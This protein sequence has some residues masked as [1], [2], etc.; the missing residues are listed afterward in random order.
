[1]LE[2]MRNQAGNWMIKIVL[3]IIAV[4]FALSFGLSPNFGSNPGIA[5]KVNGQP[6]MEEQVA[7][8]YSQ[9]AEQARQRYGDN[10][11]KLEP[12]LNL[13]EQARYD[14]MD[15]LLIMQACQDMGLSVSPA[16]VQKAIAATPFFQV[17]GKFSYDRYA[18]LLQANR[19][20]ESD[21]E[22]SIANDIIQKKLSA[23]VG[24]SAQVTP[25][26]V[27]QAL[28]MALSRIDAVYVKVS[29]AEFSGKIKITDDELQAYYEQNKGRYMNPAT[30][31][32]DYVAVPVAKFRD[33]TDI[34]EADIVDAYEMDWRKYSKPA[35]AEASH[36]LIRIPE[37]DTGQAKAK[38][39]ELMAKAKA[40]EDFATLARENSQGPTA[41]TG[42]DLGAFTKGQMV[43]PFDDMVFSMKPG[44][45]GMVQT[46]FGWHVVKL[47]DIKPARTIPLD[48]VRDEIANSLREK[49]AQRLAMEAAENIFDQLAGGAKLAA[50][51]NSYAL[52]INSTPALSVGQQIDELP[53]LEDVFKA[54]QG[55]EQGNALRPMAYK[56]GA[57][58][59]VITKRTPPEAKPLDEVKHEV[60]LAVRDKKALEAAAQKAD[61]ILAQAQKADDPAQVLIK[62]GGKPTGLITSSDEIKDL[63]GSQELVRALHLLKQDQTVLAKAAPVTDGY[64]AA[65]ITE[66]KAPSEGAIMEMKQEMTDQ[67]RTQRQNQVFARFLAD[68]RS[69]AEVL[70]PEMADASGFHLP[71][72]EPGRE[73]MW[74][75][76]QF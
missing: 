13:R 1:M 12:L 47:R 11:A 10:F 63:T 69:N 49:Q 3:A 76:K 75:R 21:Y 33:K 57:I 66:R 58:V 30:I 74:V 4:A 28:D 26:E 54:A 8:R 19:L 7:K 31:Q 29:P 23:L 45:I 15:R 20:S 71:G 32:L 39:E 41:P 38:A 16:E 67:I 60:E 24:G 36:I 61:D 2:Y 46:D 14:L 62:L 70:V 34:I 73:V 5:M 50:A 43:G 59:A 25:L 72:C 53:D 9:M 48:D 44:D 56:D 27:N 35:Q 51:A 68:L 37:G 55:L 65:V 42:G 6:I 40:G 17:D 64:A 52:N 22:S 18:K